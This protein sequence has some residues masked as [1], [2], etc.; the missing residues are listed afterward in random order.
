MSGQMPPF[1][2]IVDADD[3]ER[4]RLE[5]VHELLIAAGPLAELPPELAL[6][7]Q[8]PRAHTLTFPRRRYT[9]IAAVAIAA[10]VLFG[11]G[12]AIGSRDA[13]PAPV[14]TVAMTGAGGATATLEVLPNDE[15]GNWP[16]T[17][18]VTGL[19]PLPAGQS[20]TLWLTKNGKLA[21]SCGA[22]VVAAGTTTVPLNAPYRLKQFDD[23]VI[24]R[25]GTTEPLLSM[26]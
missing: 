17:L 22:F 3:P 10:T 5:S 2:E 13:P 4:T 24:V 12:Y 15:A 8:A 14:H 9:S 1:D 21:K 18:S 26:A 20:Y 6:A 16:M 23:W 11:V 19:P 25:T 7:P